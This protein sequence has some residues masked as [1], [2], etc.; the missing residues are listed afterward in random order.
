M[1]QTISDL[2]IETLANAG[3]KRIWGITGDSLNAVNDSIRRNGKI[4]WMH[5]RHEEAAAFAA[6]ADAA[7]SGHFAVC[8]GSS[9][10]GNLHLINGLF[11]CKRNH[12][13]VLAIA[14]HIPSSEVGLSYFQETHPQELFRECSDFAEL[15]TSPAQLPEVLHRALNV[16]V[17]GQG[18]AVLVL[19]GD[20]SLLE[21]PE[22][23]PNQWFAPA[24]P[25]V[26]PSQAALDNM[27]ELLN[28]A[29]TVTIFAGHGVGAAHD[30]VIALAQK[31]QAPIV[32]T[33][34]GKEVIEWDNPNDVG[35]TGLIGFSSGY[36]AMLN[37]DTL[38]MLGCDFPY[39][40]FYPHG[41][42][43]IQVDISPQ[44][45]GRRV[46][47]TLGV[48]GDVGETLNALLP[49]I[50]QKTE[51]KF[52]K[53]ALKHYASSREELD[54]LAKPTKAGEP[55]HPQYL[56]KVIND[57]A[58]EDAIFTVD[59]GTPIIWTAR[60]LKMNGKRRLLGSFSHGSMANALVQAM[61]AQ[62]VDKQRQVV[63]L[64][65]DGGF[66]MLMGEILTLS[67]LDLPI[68]AVIFNNASLGFV[69]M[70]M[71]VAGYLDSQTDLKNPNFAQMAEA[72]GVKG[73]RVENAE[74]LPKVLAEA[75]AYQGSAIIDV[76]VSSQELAMPPK[77]SF[78]QAK[79]FSLF[80]LK[81]ILDGRGAELKELVKTNLLG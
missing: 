29:K 32:H 4:E 76:V 71:K 5:V 15:I 73:F 75:F 43:V 7:I 1:K 59:V 9:G 38:L 18:V 35:M 24:L 65:G 28:K 49:Q 23:T 21:V 27:A 39:R 80:M 57:T 20:V 48:L 52:L 50:E 40:A 3:V 55:I 2:L 31:L 41:K 22:K 61:G 78:E 72:V 44:S 64:S 63:T 30:A 37:S 19:P 51:D 67:Q 46:P 6:G 54:K 56:A 58:A 79:G 77:I 45:L 47:L 33:L 25:R 17:G 68:K 11:D 36:H 62:A 74:D 66:S 69:A 14:S 42:T 16:V 81:A 34:R 12:V 8:A 70:E 13:P 53:N 10:P 26:V 60:Y